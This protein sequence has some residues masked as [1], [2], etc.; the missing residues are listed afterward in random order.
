[1][2]EGLNG[3]QQSN[4]RSISSFQPIIDKRSRII[5]LGSIPGVES[6][7][8]QEYYGNSRNHF[9]RIVYALYDQEPSE[10]YDERVQFLKDRK[11]A[12]WD[13]IS[14]CFREGSLDSNIKEERVNNFKDLF[15]K[16]PNVDTI[17]FNGA[18]AFDTFKK[19][20]GF[21]EFVGMTYH[22]LTSSSPANTK[23]YGE[24]LSQWSIILNYIDGSI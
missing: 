13:V 24:K 6:L 20:I 23:P 7:K 8:L 17:F 12:L 5:I 1:M 4:S 14:S 22:K 16:Y 10:A 11:I 9:W 19:L 21:N 2:D 3:F 18:K 15:V